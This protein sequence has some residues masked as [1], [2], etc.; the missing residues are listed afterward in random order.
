MHF[1][2]LPPLPPQPPSGTHTL[3]GK[4]KRSPANPELVKI[5]RSAP[6]KAY[7]VVGKVT[8][9][10][11][12]KWPQGMQDA[13]TEISRQAAQ[14]GANGVLVENVNHSDGMPFSGPS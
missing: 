12:R 6:Q 7:E 11:S 14:L 4:T 1:V 10:V 8:A 3:T 2:V 13:L 5:F 9:R